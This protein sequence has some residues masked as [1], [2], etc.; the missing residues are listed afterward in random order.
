M[1]IFLT[2]ANIN[3]HLYCILSVNLYVVLKLFP[4]EHFSVIIIVLQTRC[5][6]LPLFFLKSNLRCARRNVVSLN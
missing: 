4:E 1:V 3:A 2:A 6:M 5:I